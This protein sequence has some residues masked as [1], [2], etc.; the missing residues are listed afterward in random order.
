MDCTIQDIIIPQM[1]DYILSYFTYRVIMHSDLYCDI[2][3]LSILYLRLH[4]LDV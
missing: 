3:E 1:P 2:I 4:N